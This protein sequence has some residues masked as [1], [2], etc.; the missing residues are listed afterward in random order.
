MTLIEALDTGKKIKRQ[1]QAGRFYQLRSDYM[2]PI[3]DAIADDWIVEDDF[4][5]AKQELIEQIKNA[6]D[7]SDLESILNERKGYAG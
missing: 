3:A 1:S 2:I 4:N 6:K 5:N 7:A